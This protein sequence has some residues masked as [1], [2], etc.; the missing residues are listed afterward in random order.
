MY[1]R[2]SIKHSKHSKNSKNSDASRSKKR[3][4]GSAKK[5]IAIL[6]CTG[7]IGDNTIAAL[8][9][10]SSDVV[11]KTLVAGS[12]AKKLAKLAQ[13]WDVENVCIKSLSAGSELKSHLSD[14]NSKVY[15]G[16][17]ET[18]GIL[19]ETYHDIVVVGI[20]GIEALEYI[21][22][23]IP[24]TDVLC[25]ANKE[26]VVCA[27]S[28]IKELAKRYFTRILPL[29][30]E[31]NAIF[32]IL[33][34]DYDSS[35]IRSIILTASGGPFL[36]RAI[37]EFGSITLSE[38]LTHPNWVMGKKNTID[39]ATMVNK[40]LEVIEA[41]ELFDIGYR[42]VNIV[43][44]PQSI[45]HGVVNYTDGNSIA[46]LANPSMVIPIHYALFHPERRA[47]QDFEFDLSSVEKLEFLSPDYERYP[48]LKLLDEIMD[49]GNKGFQI[50]FNVA[51]ELAVD[52]FLSSKISFTDI[53]P[54]IANA[55]ERIVAI[56]PK[57]LDETISFIEH[58][59]ETLMCDG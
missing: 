59:R 19:S 54:T 16:K 39:S 52:S 26:G 12:N 37:S 55:L 57:T 43:I 7:S 8:G 49:T 35:H 29:D 22:S 28:M 46:H 36:H 41:C 10:H 9:Y 34:E 32:Q 18:L 58:I 25:L 4:K 30:S 44:H 53:V 51:N 20:S 13:D 50:I 56:E 45:I 3:D 6:G 1:K 24:R 23:V 47:I 5:S 14:S 42:S 2:G 17:E 11:I 21:L 31:H 38:A 33:S 40:A 15:M 48:V 27:G